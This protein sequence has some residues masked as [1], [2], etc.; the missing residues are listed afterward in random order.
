MTLVEREA[1]R[2]RLPHGKAPVPASSSSAAR[3]DAERRGPKLRPPS[4]LETGR[5]APNAALHVG[6]CH[7]VNR[8]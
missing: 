6:R 3:G 4:P 2:A 1:R 7:Y 8:A 5:Q